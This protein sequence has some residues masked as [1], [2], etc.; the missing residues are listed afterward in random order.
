MP[1]MGRPAAENGAAALDGTT[2]RGTGGNRN[3]KPLSEAGGRFECR[4]SVGIAATVPA[5][6]ARNIS[7]LQSLRRHFR[8]SFANYVSDVDR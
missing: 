3:E 4:L 2:D 7:N 8:V 1:G 5:V 6:G